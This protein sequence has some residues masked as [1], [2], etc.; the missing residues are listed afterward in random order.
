MKSTVRFLLVLLPWAAAAA[1]AA[2]DTPA[3][4]PPART[5]TFYGNAQVTAVELVI[6]V[7]DASGRVPTNLRPEDFEVI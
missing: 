7:R 6:D 5:E 1:A 4:E 3:E 2:Q